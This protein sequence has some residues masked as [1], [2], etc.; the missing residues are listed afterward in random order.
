M[1]KQI[2]ASDIFEEEDI[3]KGVRDSA[4][5]T[6]AVF[7][8]LSGE[9]KKSADEM[10]KSI[11][12]SLV[13]TTSEIEKLIQVSGKA[14][15]LTEESIKI[16]KAKAD[17]LKQHA[18]AEQQLEKIAQE[19]EKTEQQ[20]IRTAEMA[21]KAEQDEIKRSQQ[22][23]K[24][25]QD[26]T[27]AYKELSATARDMKNASKQLGAELY[28]LESSGQKGTDAYRELAKQYDSVTD[29]ASRLDAE[30]KKID[31]SVGDN[32]RNVG[33]YESA[34]KGLKQEFRA[35]TK[36]LL[37][38]DEADPRFTE[39][40]QRAGDLKD[41]IG[42]TQAV[43]KATGGTAVETMAKGLTGVGQIG[44]AAFQGIESSMV[45]MG[46]ESE[47]LM[48]TM[49]RLQALAGL[50]DA[51]ETLGGLGDKITE[52]GAAF[53]ATLA[54]LTGL[55][56]AKA[57]DVVVT[58]AETVATVTQ[59]TAT[60]TATNSTKALR[61]AMI[62]LP[63]IAILAA[64]T[65]LAY[66][67]YN[68]SKNTSDTAIAM[69]AL[70]G[71][72]DDTR[73]ALA[74]AVEVTGKMK[75]N[76]DLARDGVIS[77]EQ[78]LYEYNETL[79]DTF[80]RATDL[81]TAEQLFNDKTANYIK[82]VGLRAQ[83]NYLYQLSAEE[84]AKGLTASM[85]DQTAWYEDAFSVAK[86]GIVSIFKGNT[87]GTM[88]AMTDMVVN[89]AKNS[90]ALKVESEKRAKIY[91]DQAAALLQQAV[92]LDKANGV[93]TES[94]LEFDKAQAQK[95]KDRLAREKKRN[96]D[97]KKKDDAKINEE[98]K[99]L[100]D[101]ADFRVE[102]LLKIEIAENEYYDR[103]RTEQQKEEDAVR[104]KYF[105]LITQAEAYNKKQNELAE[106]TGNNKYL[107]NLIDTS[108]LVKAE[109]NEILVI[110]HKFAKK[111]QDQI[112]EATKKILDAETEFLTE[113][114]QAVNSDYQN[115]KD[116]I[117]KKYTDLITSAKA[118]N[119]KYL[120][121]TKVAQLNI[122]ALEEKQAKEIADLDK[123]EKDNELAKLKEHQDAI[124]EVVTQSFEI[125]KSRSEKKIELIDKEIA[126]AQTQFD[127]LQELA[128]LGNINAQQS[129]AE[130]QRI[131]AEATK[132][133]QQEER[134]QQMMELA[135]T[136]FSTYQSKVA[137]GSKTPL[138]DTI[139]DTTL[140]MQFIKTL[141]SFLEGTENTGKNGQG[142]DGKGGFHA[143]LH[144][145]ERVVPK[146]LNDQIGGLSNE[147]LTRMA[148]DYQNGKIMRQG[149][150]NAVA[151]PIEFVMMI[152]KL[153][154]L[155]S[156][157]ENK[158]EHSYEVGK[159]T[160]TM[161]EFV[162]KKNTGN[163]TMYNRYRVRK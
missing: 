154:Q 124:N 137:S 81:N 10:K 25:I 111:Y 58:E 54:K 71:S 126:A 77:K 144:P 161:L 122:K 78:A 104:E 22:K 18:L 107:K 33:N 118:Y 156:V 29:E 28:K 47:A 87:E 45:L 153:D 80:G 128:N 129:L 48:E 31:K 72:A 56:A 23:Q 147:E 138:V 149:Q 63:I 110:T 50:A 74:G 61:I 83:A 7:D 4:L 113:Y 145:N 143:V 46:V 158:P 3:F 127:N 73:T 43:I 106:K 98:K 159:I 49:V 140:L 60:N 79:G 101:V 53:K 95:E 85:E 141:P 134:K 96:D 52:I 150:A 32:Q 160:S 132:K 68:M 115:S 103:N 17:A 20:R 44:V 112:D 27:N 157:I 123:Q 75:T 51:L 65:A 57:K 121:D 142:I 35:L 146:N 148:V 14:N 119:K 102:L 117:I 93:K 155:K 114:R 99:R 2:K 125:M 84:T 86:G 89:Q 97:K 163:T 152:N 16:D 70:A 116:A 135:N 64:V 12:G 37:D 41:K 76:F 136:V 67:F 39:M 162:D 151:T 6:I 36:A 11:S 21:K 1:A 120:A 34:T 59:T 30:L 40:S 42:D 108:V 133:K 105:D 130:Q 8:K 109:T 92:E 69:E 5:Q 62:S 88:T 38:M 55:T 91:Q 100:Q 15:Q 82:A 94:D 24:T 90:Q 66:V 9:M 131:I 19:R 26:E 13:S 139:K